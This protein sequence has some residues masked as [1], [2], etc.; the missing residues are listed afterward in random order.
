M[1][2]ESFAMST[3]IRAVPYAALQIDSL[4]DPGSFRAVSVGSRDEEAIDGAMALDE[5]MRALRSLMR[6]WDVASPCFAS[7]TI[8]SVGVDD[9]PLVGFAPD[10]DFFRKRC[11]ANGRTT[12]RGSY[13]PPGVFV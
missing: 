5:V 9:G 12:K 7:S 11:M 3:A 10:E 8:G 2:E 13:S 4:D 6:G 1:S